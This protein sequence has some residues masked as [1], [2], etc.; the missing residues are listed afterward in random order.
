MTREDWATL[1]VF[2]LALGLFAVGLLFGL[3]DLHQ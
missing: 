3:F 2:G 1:A